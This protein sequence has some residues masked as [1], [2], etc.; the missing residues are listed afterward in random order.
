MEEIFLE[1]GFPSARGVRARVALGAARFVGAFQCARGRS[2]VQEWD[3]L[4]DFAWD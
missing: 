3:E 4:L 1:R 2:D